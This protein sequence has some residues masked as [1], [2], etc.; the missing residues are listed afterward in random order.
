MVRRKRDRALNSRSRVEVTVEAFW[1][2]TSRQCEAACAASFRPPSSSFEAA[3]YVAE[4]VVAEKQNGAV[5]ILFVHEDK[6]CRSGM[7]EYY[8]AQPS[9]TLAGPDAVLLRCAASPVVA[10][11]AAS[12][13][14]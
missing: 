9:I 13:R 3:S 14:R 10:R 5:A 6:L 4:A 1:R 12:K 7:Q 8:L 2:G 11:S